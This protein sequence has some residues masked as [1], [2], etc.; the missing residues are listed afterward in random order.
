MYTH[1]H[2]NTSLCRCEADILCHNPRPARHY[3]HATVATYVIHRYHTNKDII[4]HWRE[5]F[6]HHNAPTKEEDLAVHLARIQWS[7]WVENSDHAEEISFSF[8]LKTTWAGEK[9]LTLNRL[10]IM[11]IKKWFAFLFLTYF[12]SG[13]AAHSGA[14]EEKVRSSRLEHSLWV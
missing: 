14:G 11:L 6:P 7:N 4:T 10:F 2:T 13:N 9:N 1:T 12:L 5:T 8:L 3:Q